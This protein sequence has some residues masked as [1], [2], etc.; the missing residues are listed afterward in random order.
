V[1]SNSNQ[2]QQRAEKLFKKQERAEDARHAMIEY[3]AHALA[4]REKTARLRALRLAKGRL[5]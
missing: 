5:S 3:E 2:A 1:N 4:V